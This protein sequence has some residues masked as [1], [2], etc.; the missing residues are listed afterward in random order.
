MLKILVVSATIVLGSLVGVLSTGQTTPEN[1]EQWLQVSY[2]RVHTY[3]TLEM[4]GWVAQQT[5]PI[6][7]AALTLLGCI[8]YT[9]LFRKNREEITPQKLSSDE[10][11]KWTVT[12]QQSPSDTDTVKK[13]KA[14]ALKAQLVTDKMN[15]QSRQNKALQELVSAEYKKAIAETARNQANKVLEDCQKK[16]EKM[17]DHYA[18]L[19]T[20]TTKN[21]KEL[22][23]IN[24]E[25]NN[26]NSVV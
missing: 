19:K 24:E 1:I 14:R 11:V 9:L 6:V 3:I 12:T 17:C 4:G 5:A 26:L 21:D 20:E 10:L 22:Q 23:A 15:L 7:S 2:E 18:K 13:A 16:Y 25:I 8:V